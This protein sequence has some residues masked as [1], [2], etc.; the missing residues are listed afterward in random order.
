MKGTVQDRLK[1]LAETIY[2]TSREEFRDSPVKKKVRERK[3]GES[4][5]ERMMK[6]ITKEKND[7]RKRWRQ[8]DPTERGHGNSF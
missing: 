5:R 7:L 3:G 4:R 8:A 2:E 1:R 6:K